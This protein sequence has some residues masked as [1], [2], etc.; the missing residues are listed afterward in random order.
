MALLIILKNLNSL[1]FKKK[2]KKIS[3]TDWSP[4]TYI[5]KQIEHNLIEI[6]FILNNQITKSINFKGAIS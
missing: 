5:K 4:T 6:T 2:K 3:T 1:Q